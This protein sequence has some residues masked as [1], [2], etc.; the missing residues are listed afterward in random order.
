MK[1]QEVLAMLGE[2]CD[3]KRKPNFCAGLRFVRMR[4]KRLHRGCQYVLE[5]P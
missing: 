1:Y 2:E 3:W 5:L 4:A